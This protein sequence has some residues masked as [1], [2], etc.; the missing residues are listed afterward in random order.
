[1]NSPLSNEDDIADTDI[2]N[3]QQRL[4]VTAKGAGEMVVSHASP[5][6]CS[7]L[8]IHDASFAFPEPLDVREEFVDLTEGIRRVAVFDRATMTAT[9]GLPWEYTRAFIS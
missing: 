4:M 3:R 8:G 6:A 1:M 7:V 5:A 9:N 2:S